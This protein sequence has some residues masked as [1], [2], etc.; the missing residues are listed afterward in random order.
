MQ[1]CCLSVDID[2]NG[3]VVVLGTTAGRFIV[4]SNLDGLHMLSLQV[5]MQPL[6][7]LGFSPGQLLC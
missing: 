6:N 2:I 5:S 1:F 4:L 3:H 7:T